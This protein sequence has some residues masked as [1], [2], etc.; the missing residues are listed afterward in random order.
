MRKASALVVGILSVLLADGAFAQAFPARPITLINPYAAGG[1][2]DVLARIVAA[3]MAVPLGQNVIV[4]NKPGAGT[5]IG[6]Q[7][8]ARAKPD[9]YTL[10]IGGS[11][12]HVITPALIKD[13]QYD[14]I[15]DF[16]FIATVGS[17]PNVLAV[18]AKKPWNSV[19]DLV[20]AARSGDL[21]VA[22]V[23]VGS[24]PQ[25]LELLLQQRAGI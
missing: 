4:D 10:L 18:P 9:G 15:A 3:R 5:A 24:I 17:V 13:A 23:G 14:G 19:K 20:D 2:A 22:H 8:V 1:P 25:L 21:S 12:S 11:P 6:A 7:L 16:V